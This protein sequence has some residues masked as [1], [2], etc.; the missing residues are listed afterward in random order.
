[1]T[2]AMIRQLPYVPTTDASRVYLEISFATFAFY[3]VL[4]HPLSSR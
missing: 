2:H 3:N 1:M 4:H